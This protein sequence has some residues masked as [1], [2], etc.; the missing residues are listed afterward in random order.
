MSYFL[1]VAVSNELHDIIKVFDERLLIEDVSSL[2]VGKATLGGN[3]R[4]KAFLVMMN[5]C[6]TDLLDAGARKR[7]SSRLFL[8]GL[9]GI[10]REAP[11]VSILAH[12]FH[13]PI[14]SES[15]TAAQKIL[16][17]FEELNMIYPA[18]EQ[19]VRYVITSP[20]DRPA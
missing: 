2:P 4:S 18:I 14:S 19:D 7:Y 13:G 11:S 3:Q 12:W 9:E 1:C 20:Q 15:V 10:L 17:S 6:S 8:D 5:G 16:M